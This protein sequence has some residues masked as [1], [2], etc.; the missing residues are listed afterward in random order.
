MTDGL[1]ANFDRNKPR[2]SSLAQALKE[3]TTL[4]L[5]ST[6][7]VETIEEVVCDTFENDSDENSRLRRES[8]RRGSGDSNNDNNST[9]G[10]TSDSSQTPTP[11]QDSTE[12]LQD[13]RSFAVYEQHNRRNDLATQSAVVHRSVSEKTFSV[14]SHEKSLIRVNT[15]PISLTKNATNQDNVLRDKVKSSLDMNGQLSDTASRSSRLEDG[16]SEISF[17]ISD[18]EEGS[19]AGNLSDE[20]STSALSSGKKKKKKS[21]LRKLFHRKSKVMS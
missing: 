11:P 4:T 9:G 7:P 21:A 10:W 3:V 16:Q 14:R 12:K 18:V 19:D 8:L 20:S 13:K 2:R 6:I 5:S 15:E 17:N 1:F